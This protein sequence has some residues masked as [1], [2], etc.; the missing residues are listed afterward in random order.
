MMHSE[1]QDY[2]DFSIEEEVPEELS[3]DKK[4]C[5][6]CKQPI[7]KDSLFCLFCGEPATKTKKGNW[8]IL[9]AL[10]VLIVFIV[11]VLAL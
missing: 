2:F 11:W 10:I 3:S 8:I 9:V 6:H 4:A 7:P 1:D 5:P